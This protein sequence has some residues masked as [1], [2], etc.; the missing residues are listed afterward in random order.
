MLL[1][2]AAARQGPRYP[3]LA[4]AG[5]VGPS[6]AVRAITPPPPPT[7]SQLA[8]PVGAKRPPPPP[9]G[10]KKGLPP[11]PP[12]AG[13]KLATSAGGG[14]SSGAIAAPSASWRS[15]AEV[16]TMMVEYVPTFY[17][18]VNSVASILD[19]S[20]RDFV[21]GKM[22]FVQFFRKY[23]FY[24][25]LRN[26]DGV[27]MEVKLRDDVQHPRRGAADTKFSLSDIGEYA[28]YSVKP[29]FVQS[30]DN[31][32]TRQDLVV[33]VRPVAPPPSVQVRLEERVPVM[34]RLKAI[35]P[36]KELTNIEQVEELVP[37]DIL[38][39]PYF[40]CQGGLIAIA[41]K[42]PDVFQ[43]VGGAIRHRPRH[44][45]P[46]ALDDYDADT[47][48]EP[49]VLKLVLD[50][51]NQHDVPV[52][53]S[54]TSLY[55]Q[56]TV[57]QRRRLK[58]SHKSFASFLRA[59]GKCLAVSVDLLKVSSWKAPAN[60]LLDD[61]AE[62]GTTTPL[63]GGIVQYTHTHVLN[64]LFDCFPRGQALG[65]KAF[66]DMVPEHLRSS[67]P[68]NVVGWLAS[69]RTYFVVDGA[70]L[71]P[72]DASRVFIRRAS[73]H[74]PLDV[75]LALYRYI[76]EDG[77][78]VSALL[79]ALPKATQAHVNQV[80]IKGVVNSLPEWLELL[81]GDVFRRRTVEELET[82]LAGGGGKAPPGGVK[83]PDGSTAKGDDEDDAP[84]DTRADEPRKP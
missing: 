37:E 74:A 55:E 61:A 42:F 24:F 4:A 47:T 59:H 29:E 45:A 3:V 84:Q 71:T 18:P 28:T 16:L 33:H 11:P 8:S 56:L 57:P 35:V 25:D 10:G 39:H 62:P 7:T 54:V 32:D 49:E 5:L 36:T 21:K 48:P 13:R 31:I 83:R 41:S 65:L 27:R 50:S 1:L 80:G 69:N 34:E 22:K 64:E 20:A 44:L 58:K 79:E 46:L 78:A 63:P 72:P 66:M 15:P 67:L 68:K 2:R 60:A 12:L 81:D 17:V 30:L 75:A 19:D 38:F 53:V 82:A 70:D 23:R 26:V 77:I 14:T 52:W 76:P 43:I 6:S 9:L 73:D 40:D 51:V